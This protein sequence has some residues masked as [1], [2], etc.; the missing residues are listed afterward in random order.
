VR[1]DAGKNLK[2]ITRSKQMDAIKTSIQMKNKIVSTN[3]RMQHQKGY[4]SETP[5]VQNLPATLRNEY[6]MI[7]AFPPGM[8]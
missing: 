1:L 3:F 2:Y 4:S 7:F 8:S 6:H 5:F